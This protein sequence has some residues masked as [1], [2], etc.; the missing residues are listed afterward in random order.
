MLVGKH[1]VAGTS[2][3]RIAAAVGVSEPA[4]YRHFEN[5]HQMLLASLDALYAVIFEIIDS[6]ENPDALERLREISRTHMDYGANRYDVV[7]SSFLGF[8][9]SPV[10]TGFR[11]EFEIRQEAATS[12]LAVIVEEGKTQGTVREDVDAQETAWE[13]VGAFWADIVARGVLR[14]VDKS[15]TVRMVDVIL[16][17]VAEGGTGGPG[18]RLR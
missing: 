8:V 2:T 9:S 17:S 18:T 11:H 4:L 12:A 15:W 3:A 7:V 5:R 13:L 14:S 10:E 16:E 6:S 1:G